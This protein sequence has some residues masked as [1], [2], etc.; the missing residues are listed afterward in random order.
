MMRRDTNYTVLSSTTYYECFEA[1]T[2]LA[3]WCVIGW[4]VILL[5]TFVLL[6]HLNCYQVTRP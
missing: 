3:H 6:H 2:N 1:T 5:K 4:N